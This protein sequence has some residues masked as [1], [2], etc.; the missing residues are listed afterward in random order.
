MN[1]VFE[2]DSGSLGG[3]VYY[4]GINR[5]HSS[6]GE[7][8]Q[9]NGHGDV[10]QL[11]DSLGTIVQ[12]YE[13]DAFGNE[14]EPSASDT[15]PFRYCGEYFDIESGTIYLRA[16]YYDPAIGRF[17]QQDA[18][19]YANPG[20]PLSL[21]LYVYCYGNPVRYKDSSGNIPVETIGDIVSI[22]WSGIDLVANP[23]LANLG[24]LAWDIG[25]A[26]LPYVPGSYVAKGIK[27]VGKADDVIG[28]TK[29]FNK[30]QNALEAAEIFKKHSKS[31][32]D[33]YTEIKKIVDSL[34]IKGYEVHH[35]IEKRFASV[36]GLKENDIL[37]VALDKDTHKAI[38]EKF[39]A[40]ILYN[41]RDV[42]KMKQSD[43]VYTFTATPQN[44]WYAI[45]Y[46]YTETGNA[47]Y[48]PM[49]REYLYN[50]ANVELLS[51]ISDWG[52]Y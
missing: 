15:N 6:E 26:L 28:I 47:Q 46:A 5:T 3:T 41:L 39:R 20:D 17:T 44:I 10:V 52:G 38:T 33:S 1:L 18:W 45:C 43:K 16:R 31:I 29:A 13:Y 7:F 48:I 35:L 27:F 40:K 12:H 2:Y 9:Y 8:Y 37:S 11:T 49:I 23:S 25:A 19:G 32:V 51:K 42:E 34:G 50:N 36:F 24:Y 14:V 21:N 22:L 30:A 4:Y